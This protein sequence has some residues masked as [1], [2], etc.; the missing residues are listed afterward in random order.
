MDVTFFKSPAEWR[1]W[2]EKH[3]ASETSLLV[4]FYKKDSGK[5]NMTYQQA[6]DEALCFGWIDGVRGALDD[7][8]YTMKFHHRKPHSIWSAINIRRIGEL[9]EQGLVHPYGQ[10]VFDERDL[11][12]QKLY[13][14]EQASIE[15]PP[16]YEAQFRANEK[17]WAFFQSRQPSY[18]KPALWWVISAK[19]EATRLKRLA[20]LIEDSAAGRKIAPL[21]R[22]SERE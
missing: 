7:E 18:R 21:T 2:L 3:H 8:S 14:N 20:T 1:A 11:S 5:L 17:A 13:S 9:A 4:G 16:D 19:Q 22:K 6:L 10:K 15:L 12:K